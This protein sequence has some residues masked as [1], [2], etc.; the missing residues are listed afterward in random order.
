M[1][2]LLLILLLFPMI[3]FS[4]P[5]VQWENT[6]GGSGNDVAHSVNQTADGG[7]I[8]TGY[9]NSFSS[10][11]WNSIYLL[12]TDPNGVEEWYQTLG[13]NTES[14]AYE[15]QQT[16]D[17]GYIITGLK[18]LPSSEAFLIKTN[19]SG[20]IIWEQNFVGTVS[21][22]SVK[23]TNDNGYIITGWEYCNGT[24]CGL[25]RKI[26][27]NGNQ[28]WSQPF[29][30]SLGSIGWDIEQTSDDGYVIAG[31][32]NNA[33]VYL[34][35]TASNGVEQW[36]QFFEPGN[37][38]NYG[39]SIE[40]TDDNGYIITGNTY[41]NGNYGDAFLLKTDSTGIQQWVKIFG[42]I[43]PDNAECV[44]QTNDGG[45]IITGVKAE[46]MI[47]P[48]YYQDILVVK[49]NENGIEEWSQTF[50]SLNTYDHGYSIQ[51]TNDG[52]YIISGSTESFGN[53]GKDVYLIK[54]A[55]CD[56]TSSSISAEGMG[57]Y[58]AP[59]GAIYT[60][61]GVYTDT[62]PNAAGCDSI[63]T[64]NLSMSHSGIGELNNTPKQ[65]IKIVDV[66]GRETPFK[67]NTPLLYIYNDGTVERKMIIKE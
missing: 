28:L 62:I 15:V 60:T 40:Q 25:L 48:P 65:L 58:T 7:Y 23:Q 14:K 52:G 56:N 4:Q 41:D 2:T 46:P 3:G 27:S 66:L 20:T 5:T 64:I 24:N 1:R 26:D 45:Y 17:G 10:G 55:G 67:P 12:K 33:Q 61:G 43:G 42:A 29:G 51:Q 19:S 22:H 16:N 44:Q 34:I 6:F 35:K 32:T 13:G 18:G 37:E 38:G 31:Y 50:G 30:I 53:G 47:G 57:S 54:L 49:T 21:G 8:V 59:S 11:G 36:S 9:T 39:I 63:I